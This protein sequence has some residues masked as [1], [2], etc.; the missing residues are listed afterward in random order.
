[1]Q[2]FSYCSPPPDGLTLEF[3][4]NLQE[5]MI[6]MPKLLKNNL[7]SFYNARITLILKPENNIIA[8]LL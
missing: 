2:K 8:V 5:E 3:T 1:M 7:N 4:P 6:H